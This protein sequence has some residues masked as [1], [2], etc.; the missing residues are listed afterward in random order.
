DDDIII[1]CQSGQIIRVS[2]DEIST[3]GRNT[4]GVRI[5]TLHEGDTIQD[6]AILK[7]DL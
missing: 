6:A 5:V 4:Q 2:A 7:G 1:I 3:Q